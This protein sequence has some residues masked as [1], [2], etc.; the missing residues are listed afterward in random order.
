MI[1]A[2]QATKTKSDETRI[3]EQMDKIQESV[4][5]TF[6]RKGRKAP[7]IQE[8]QDHREYAPLATHSD[9]ATIN[10]F[11]AHFDS[12]ENLIDLDNLADFL[13]DDTTEFQ[14]ALLTFPFF[15]MSRQLHARRYI[16]PRSKRKFRNRQ[17]QQSTGAS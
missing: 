12:D 14:Y 15:D 11:L 13:P 2:K 3:H 17:S 10:G 9:I 8:A 1:I 4:D 5:S 6:A 16:E 7:T